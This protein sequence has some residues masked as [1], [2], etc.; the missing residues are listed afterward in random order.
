MAHLSTLALAATIAGFA[1]MVIQFL[2]QRH[3]VQT[4]Q[5]AGVPM[6]KYHPVFGHLLALKE[7]MKDLP[8]DATFH[9]VVQRLARQFFPDGIFYLSLWPFHRTM[10]VVADPLVAAQVEAANLDKPTSITSTMETINGGPSLMSMHGAE[11]KEW[12]TL[13]NPGFAAGYMNGLAPAIAEEVSVFCRLLQGLAKQDRVFQLEEYTLRLTFDII[14]RVTFG[15]R[16]RYQEKGSPLADSLRRQILWTPFAKS[17]NP[18][19]RWLSIRPLVQKYNSYRMNLY[20][21]REIDLLFDNLA[22]S[23]RETREKSAPERSII[24]LAMDKYLENA[25]TGNLSKQAFRDFAKPQLRMFLFAGHDTT[26]STLLYCYYLLATHPRALTQVRAEHDHIFGNDFSL[27]ATISCIKGDPTLMNKIPYTSAVIK[28]TLRIFPPAASLRDG[29]ADIV[30]RDSKG[31]LYP[32]ADCHIWTLNLI[33]HN[34]PK[35]FTDATSFRPERWLAQPGDPMHPQKGSWRPFEWGP[36]NC[37]G[38]T[39]AQLELKV[40]LVLTIRMFDITPAYPEW[41]QTH[42]KGGVKLV[43]GNRA[44]QAQLGGG[45]AHPA[46]EFPVRVAVRA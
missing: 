27:E 42:G 1:Y 3:H 21:D 35:I 28:E 13:F 32:T 14:G 29:R 40:A 33:M 23:R 24:A 19:K 45:G 17:L 46:D 5:A 15:G 18:L 9:V 41:D 20:L 25:A 12:R 36:R 43:D 10:L 22:T 8:A 7:C 11:W 39:L 38:Q 34:D 6:P 16:L 30:L 4:L 26:S 44:Y 2:H 37:I 31:H